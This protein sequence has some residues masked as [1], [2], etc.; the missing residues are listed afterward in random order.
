MTRRIFGFIVIIPAVALLLAAIALAVLAGGTQARE[1]PQAAAA[2]A[3]APPAAAPADQAAAPHQPQAVWTDIAPFPTV[4]VSPTPGTY[5]LRLKRAA[6]AAYFPNNKVYV[7]GGRHGIDGEDVALQWIWEYTPGANTWAL[8]N[9][10]LDGSAPGARFTANMAAAVLTDANGVRIYAIGGSSIDSVPATT[11]R[12]YDPGTD[13][14]SNLTT[15]PWPATPARIPGGYAV[16]NNK[17]YI[18][19][20]YSSIGTGGVFTDTWRFDPLAASGSRWTQLPTANLN[21]GRGYI[22]GRGPRW[23]DLRHRRR[24]LGRDQPPVGLRHQCRAAGPFPGQSDLD[25]AGRPAHGAWRHERL[26]LRYRRSL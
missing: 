20:G 8:K 4:S 14:I 21:L 18:F 17:L 11:V 24:Y 25:G 16:V 23:H 9:A 7:L 13:T 26:G 22:A 1:A 19:G 3:A 12:V 6:A 10:L 2:N 5:P 15:D